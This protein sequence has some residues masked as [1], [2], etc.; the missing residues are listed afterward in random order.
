MIHEIY[1][2][3]SSGRTIYHYS[4]KK[5]S[6]DKQIISSL[7][8]AFQSFSDEVFFSKIQKIDLENRRLTFLNIN[9]AD[10]LNKPKIPLL[11]GFCISDLVD[12]PLALEKF[13]RNV[14][15]QFVIMGNKY[16]YHKGLLNQYP[17]F[18]KYI[19]NLI[20]SS[21]H[22]RNWAFTTLS[23]IISIFAFYIASLIFYQEGVV[24]WRDFLAFII[25]A[26]L[27]LLSGICSGTKISGIIIPFI[28]TM[29]LSPIIIFI[30]HENGII[31][32]VFSAASLTSISGFFGGYIAERFWLFKSDFYGYNW[33]FYLIL[34]VISIILFNIEVFCIFPSIINCTV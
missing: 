24:E 20:K 17:E 15:K 19:L 2:I 26:S 13:L 3:D 33:K 23:S 7:I 18:D 29:V 31:S 34:I 21:V 12:H 4:K 14:L 8:T 30:F 27:M 11:L 1:I 10:I 9:P 25:G 22:P 16:N 6:S 28:T 32:F 5:T